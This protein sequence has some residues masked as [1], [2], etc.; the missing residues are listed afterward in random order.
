ME[1]SFGLI[2]ELLYGTG[3]EWGLPHETLAGLDGQLLEAVSS[4]RRTAQIVHTTRPLSA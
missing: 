4:S 2:A 3:E 1:G